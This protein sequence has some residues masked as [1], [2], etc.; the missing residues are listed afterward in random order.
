[1]R[2]IYLNLAGFTAQI[3]K[4]PSPCLLPTNVM[5]GIVILI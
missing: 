4:G 2:P 3:G 5:R 1:M